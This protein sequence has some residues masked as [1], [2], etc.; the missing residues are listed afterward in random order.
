MR[1]ALRHP[2]V[3][4][5]AAAGGG[6]YATEKRIS[7]SGGVESPNLR[8]AEGDNTWDLARR[9]A[10]R[11]GGPD[12][13]WMIY[14]GTKGFNYENNLEYMDFLSSLEIEFER[15]IVPGVPH[16]ATDIYAKAAER[17]MRFHVRNFEAAPLK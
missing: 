8:F 9:Y 2:D 7:E 3:F 1:L 12:V 11:S 13:R 10:G 17:I 14:V 16:S 6:G 5:S 4:C 15:L